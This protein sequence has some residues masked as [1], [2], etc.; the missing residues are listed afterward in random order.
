MA[1]AANNL[2]AWVA[3]ALST[4]GGIVT[5]A[6]HYGSTSQ[7]ISA[8]QQKQTDLDSHVAKHDDQLSKI[9]QDSAAIKQ[10][11]DDIKDTVH[12]M[13]DNGVKRK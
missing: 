8:I 11:V 4:G 3:I 9:Q 1:L 2:T 12:D 5:T 10:S 13:R 7:Q 6:I